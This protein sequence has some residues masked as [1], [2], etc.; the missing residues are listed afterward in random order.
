MAYNESLKTANLKYY[1]NN[2]KRVALN[3]LR[4]DYEK[5]IEP[6][7]EKS[8]KP[9]STFI[10]EAVE[11]KLL[12]DNLIDENSKYELAY[13]LDKVKAMVVRD[14][15]K[16]L[17]KDC[18]AII[19]YGSCARGDFTNESDVDIAILT[20]SNREDVKK[21]DAK[22]DDIATTI[23]L[24]TM[25]IVN[26]VCLPKAEYEEKNSWYPYFMNIKKEG[27]MLYEQ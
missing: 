21:Y 6:A 7:I 13:V 18:R 27:I 19:L 26:F 20:N 9:I 17:K 25:A 2:Q 5:R 14:I 15:P 3:W 12:R 10:K 22:I 11:E 8:G 16:A 23:G 4:Y 1:K 24:D